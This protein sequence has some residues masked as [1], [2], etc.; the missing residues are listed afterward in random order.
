MSDNEMLVAVASILSSMITIVAVASAFAWRNRRAR[1]DAELPAGI[2]ERLT[3]IEQGV[4]AIAI[5]MERVSEGQR[6]TTRLLAD[7]GAAAPASGGP[8]DAR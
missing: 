6:F 4:D 7:R 3:R 8:H 5:E 2:E 1:R